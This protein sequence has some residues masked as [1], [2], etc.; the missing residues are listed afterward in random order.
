MENNP[1][2]DERL[3]V[4]TIRCLDEPIQQVEGRT[5][6]AKE[7]K[8]RLVEVDVLMESKDGH[9]FLN[10]RLKLVAPDGANTTITEVRALAVKQLKECVK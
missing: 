10:G 2:I 4:T 3:Q 6:S 7:A 1:L 5:V 9:T 8:E